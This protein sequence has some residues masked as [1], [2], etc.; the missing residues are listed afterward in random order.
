MKKI[1]ISRTDSI[2]DVI[3][4]LPFCFALKRKF[5]EAQLLFLAAPYTI[6]VLESCSEIDEII[7]L[8]ELL[9]GTLE[10]QIEKIKQLE[11]DTI[12]HVFPKKE[13][14]K[15]AKKA[16]IPTRI[17]TSHRGF[18]LLTCNQR[19]DFTRKNSE[20]HEA[21]LNFHLGRTLGFKNLPSWDELNND[22]SYFKP[23][24]KLELSALAVD[25]PKVILH[26]KSQGSAVEWPMEKYEALA[27]KLE[28]S[29]CRVFFTGTEKEGLLIRPE[30][31]W[32]ENI[33]D[34][35]GKF[36]LEE[37]ISFINQCDYLVACSTGPLHIAGILNKNCLGLFTPKKP[38]HPGRWRPLGNNSETITSKESCTCKN[39]EN[40]SCLKEI[41]IESVFHQIQN[42][43]NF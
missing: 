32:T 42:K 7:N 23:S 28:E 27:T 36:T 21:Q 31:N 24:K 30:M 2:G 1:L 10:A 17:G 37:L 16:K 38:M 20:F 22:L 13:I 5:P 14:A 12:V 29:G 25:K 15:L 39:K 35:T 3:L 26:A 19:I 8:N 9:I 11:I 4:T 40:C 41:T 33:I 6:P 34:T 43:L 18:H